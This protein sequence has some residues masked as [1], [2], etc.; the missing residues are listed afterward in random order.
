MGEWVETEY[1]RRYRETA[2]TSY[3]SFFITAP[4]E[5]GNR[6]MPMEACEVIMQFLL[7]HIN[8]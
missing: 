3:T 1:G 4:D 7:L 6:S 2:D 5:G 8:I